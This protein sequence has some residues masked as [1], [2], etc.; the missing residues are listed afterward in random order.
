MNI[1]NRSRHLLVCGVVALLV[2][3]GCIGPRRRIEPRPLPPDQPMVGEQLWR[4]EDWRTYGAMEGVA[5]DPRTGEIYITHDRRGRSQDWT[6]CLTK[7]D[8]SGEWLEDWQ[9]GPFDKT[10][11]GNLR[12]ADLTGR[13]A[14]ALLMSSD[15]W[16]DA[17]FGLTG[18]G[19]VLWAHS[20]G[21]AINDA[22]PTDLDGDGRD[23][24]IL[25]LNAG[26]L[27]LLDADGQ[28]RW[29]LYGKH[30]IDSRTDVRLGNVWSV[31]AGP[32]GDDGRMQIVTVSGDSLCK[33][34]PDG[35][36]VQRIDPELLDPKYGRRRD[37]R[38]VRM[39]FVGPEEPPVIVAMCNDGHVLTGLNADGSIRW[40]RSFED[41]R[42]T[43]THDPVAA[44]DQPL[45]AIPT[46]DGRVHVHD[47]RTGERLV[48]LRVD[49]WATL[50]WQPAQANEPPVL[51]IAANPSL[52]AYRLLPRKA[53]TADDRKGG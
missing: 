52:T 46:W 27:V 37:V 49:P 24:V 11:S 43:R 35:T 34:E 47:V 7:L 15:V 41:N 39:G 1:R 3:G 19:D 21:P 50:A 44:P 38:H 32:V 33:V 20:P 13:A 8:R 45:I 36:V 10:G 17:V 25:G 26:G 28:Q 42:K 29:R 9:L 53:A 48:S 22:L 14:P 40:R 51:I 16:S 30:K 6:V 18:D 4:I 2:L 12:F 23:E 31:A 5:V